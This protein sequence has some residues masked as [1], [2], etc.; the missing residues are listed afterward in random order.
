M[1]WLTSYLLP[2]QQ[3]TKCCLKRLGVGWD[4][5]EFLFLL[6][7]ICMLLLP[8]MVL[9][10]IVQVFDH[11]IIISDK[12]WRMLT[13]FASII[14][15]SEK[16]SIT[17][18]QKIAWTWNRMR[19]P[20]TAINVTMTVTTLLDPPFWFFHKLKVRRHKNIWI[21]EKIFYTTKLWRFKSLQIQNL[22]R[23]DQTM[24]FLFQIHPLVCKQQN[25]PSTKTSWIHHKSGTISASVSLI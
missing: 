3:E 24:Q 10:K 16:Y 11:A 12:A 5:L 4:S 25:Q 18:L 13:L 17:H 2:R 7:T 6:L 21:H 14:L 8:T 15:V 19:Q 23:H 20:A 9:L 22:R 1:K